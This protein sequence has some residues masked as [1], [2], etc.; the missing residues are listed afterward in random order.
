MVN[1]GV[2]KLSREPGAQLLPPET[3][4]HNRVEAVTLDSRK[5]ASQALSY[6]ALLRGVDHESVN[7]K[8]RDRQ[9]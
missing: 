3:Q 2:E 1:E 4:T 5:R 7:P 6:L 8:S 9:P